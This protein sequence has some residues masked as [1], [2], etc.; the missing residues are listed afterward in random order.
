M[1]IRLG[2]KAKAGLCGFKLYALISYVAVVKCLMFF[3]L[4]ILTEKINSLTLSKKCVV[5]HGDSI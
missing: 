1:Q 4:C 2:I 3:K 5:L